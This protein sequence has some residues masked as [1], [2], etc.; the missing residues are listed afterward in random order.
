VGAFSETCKKRKPG[1][2]PL[3]KSLLLSETQQGKGRL[4]VGE[5]KGG[6]KIGQE[7]HCLGE[8]EKGE[9]HVFQKVP[10]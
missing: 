4:T 5:R 10:T 2:S 6:R 1:A 8:K 9:S 3:S 7:T